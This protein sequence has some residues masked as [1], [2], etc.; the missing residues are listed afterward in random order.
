MS[1]FTLLVL[2]RC[3]Q[4]PTSNFTGCRWHLVDNTYLY[5]VD[6]TDVQSRWSSATIALDFMQ[7]LHR[8]PTKA[9]LSISYSTGSRMAMWWGVIR[10]RFGTDGRRWQAR[11]SIWGSPGVFEPQQ[12][13][14]TVVVILLL[15]S[16]Y[17]VEGASLIDRLFSQISLLSCLRHTELR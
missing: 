1:S 15:Y 2:M 7:G 14:R 10:K 5:S 17:W 6:S 8:K 12:R 9:L 3:L 13:R 16:R 4:A 11:N